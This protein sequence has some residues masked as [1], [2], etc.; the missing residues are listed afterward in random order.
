MQRALTRLHS[1][2]ETCRIL[3]IGT[4]LKSNGTGCTLNR[5]RLFVQHLHLRL[6]HIQLAHEPT[7]N[8]FVQLSQQKRMVYLIF[9][10]HL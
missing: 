1:Q 8:H 3:K 10:V 4:F 7:K 6:G 2:K 5:L 9:G